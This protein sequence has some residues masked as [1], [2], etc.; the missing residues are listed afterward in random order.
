MINSLII[1]PSGATFTMSSITRLPWYV[2]KQSPDGGD[3][4]PR[5][6]DLGPDEDKLALDHPPQP[7][8]LQSE[9]ELHYPLAGSSANYAMLYLMTDWLYGWDKTFT[10]TL[11]QKSVFTMICIVSV[12]PPFS[13]Q[14]NYSQRKKPTSMLLVSNEKVH[15]SWRCTINEHQQVPLRRK[16]L[17]LL[18]SILHVCLPSDTG[19]FSRITCADLGPFHWRASYCALQLTSS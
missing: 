9:Q 16:Y 7:Y 13:W 2:E 17:L 5:N 4:S 15:G 14:L 11:L 10:Q 18:D 3:W 8:T 12:L 6:R 1:W 19:D